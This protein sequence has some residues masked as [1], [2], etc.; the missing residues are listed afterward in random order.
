MWVERAN[1]GL[2]RLPVW[3][4]YALGAV[5]AVGL[6]WAAA[7]GGLGVD[8]VKA[9]ERELGLIALQLIVAG[10]AVTPLRWATGLSLIRFRRAIGVL[11]FAYAALHVAVWVALDFQF[12]WAEIG[13]EIVKRPYV[14][15]GFAAFVALLPLAVT[16]NDRSVRAMGAAA[17]RS[18]HRL[19]YPAAVL[20]GV[21]F[22]W[23]V[24]AWP[25]E[26][27]VYL[28]AILGLLAVRAL[29]RL[30]AA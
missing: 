3:A 24:K 2:R 18:L 22:L 26:P 8:P 7:T 19:V 1:G 4:V 21:H 13:T 23:L 9:I 29:R 17:W 14:L 10:L 27:M 11:A 30:R 25:V 15:V 16:S 28:A 6:F 12:R 5:P 20:A